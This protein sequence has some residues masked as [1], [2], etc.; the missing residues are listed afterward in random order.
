MENK[1][2]DPN[3]E[4]NENYEN[5][6]FHGMQNPPTKV[7]PCLHY[8]ICSFCSFF[9]FLFVII[10]FPENPTIQ[11]MYFLMLIAVVIFY[12]CC[13]CCCSY[14]LSLSLSH[15]FSSYLSFFPPKCSYFPT[16]LFHFCQSDTN[17]I[18]PDCFSTFFFVLFYV[19]VKCF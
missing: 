2:T 15:T 14:Q 3:A 13:Y 12:V 1:P 8:I 18:Y 11:P 6:P 5:L 16:F 7:S 10:I 4:P 9:F 17:P 19:P